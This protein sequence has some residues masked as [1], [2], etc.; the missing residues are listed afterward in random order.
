V[1]QHD[2]RELQLAKGAI[3]CGIDTLLQNAASPPLI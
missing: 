2:I 1:T 3:R